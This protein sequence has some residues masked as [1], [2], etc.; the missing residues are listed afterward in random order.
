MGTLPLAAR[1]YLLGVIL[2][3]L[4]FFGL[5]LITPLAWSLLDVFVSLLACAALIYLYYAPIQF[6]LAPD[7]KVAFPVDDALILFCISALGLHGIWVLASAIILSFVYQK[8]PLYRICFNVSTLVIAYSLAHVV[9]NA[10]SPPG[11]IPYA[12][13]TG[14]LV[15][16][17]TAGTYY[18]L[19]YS[20]LVV[21]LALATKKRMIKAYVAK[22]LPVAPVVAFT[23]TCG[24]TISALYAADPWLL[25]FGVVLVVL[26]RYTY[27]IVV[28]LQVETQRRQKLDGDLQRETALLAQREALLAAREQEAAHLAHDWRHYLYDI[29][30]AL[31]KAASIGGDVAAVPGTETERRSRLRRAIWVLDLMRDSLHEFLDA[32]QLATNRLVL[33]KEP[34][35]LQEV[36]ARVVEQIQP[37]LE[38]TQLP[39]NIYT[40]PSPVIC[41]GDARR[42][43][44]VLYNL[45][46]N[47]VE[48]TPLNPATPPAITIWLEG[49]DGTARIAVQD[50]GPG[51]SQV[52][53]D[54]LG[55]RFLRLRNS[56]NIEG[57]GLGLSFCVRVLT[58]HDGHLAIT[59]PGEG[60]GATFTCL[61]PLLCAPE[62]S[63]AEGV[64]PLDAETTTTV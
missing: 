5:S 56:Q 36:I 21:M 49:I 50:T 9:F 23:F 14:V 22:V 48:I 7:Q 32:T 12:G 42:L 38:A 45:L 61:I 13:P 34:V 28:A 62:V 6:P 18:F 60:Q 2:A 64:L 59:S 55:E 44:R 46:I 57:T 26:A 37:R 10:L 30:Q 20:I 24:A 15:F 43:G 3:A 19:N 31:E 4:V 29:R 53:I 8:L 51:L 47:A 41:L 1:A 16:V 58:L 54:R 63:Q 25:G 17:A 35:V 27:S 39:L 52:E 40:P 11:A 33:R